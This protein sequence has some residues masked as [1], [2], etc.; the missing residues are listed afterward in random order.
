MSNS[1]ENSTKPKNF[2]ELIHSWS[3]W[4]SVIGVVVGGVLGFLYYYNVGCS[5]GSCGITSSPYG[6]IAI[7]GIL[8]YFL[9]NGGCK[10]CS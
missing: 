3:F 4:K 9:T 1:C 5:T 7:G 10:A 6:S 8:G 2:K